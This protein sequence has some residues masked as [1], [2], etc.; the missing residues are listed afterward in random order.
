V[1]SEVRAARAMSALQGYVQVRP[2]VRFDEGSRADF[3]LTGGGPD[4]WVEVKSVTLMRTPG[5]AEF[6]DTK[7]ARGAKHQAALA[8]RVAAGDQATV[9]YV[10]MRTDCTA[11]QV[12]ADIDPAYAAAAEAAGLTTLCH[13]AQ[14]SPD[15]I[16]L[17]APVPLR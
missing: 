15:D 8:R 7:T 16:T 17:G 10:L 11:M 6:P 5:R 14:I 9:L 13:A 3:L 4:H 2:G 1:V 12:A